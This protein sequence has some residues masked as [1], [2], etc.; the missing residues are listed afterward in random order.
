METDSSKNLI[1]ISILSTSSNAGKSMLIRLLHQTGFIESMKFF[2]TDECTLVNNKSVILRRISSKKDADAKEWIIKSD[3]VLLVVRESSTAND[4]TIASLRHAS[5]KK[6]LFIVRTHIDEIVN[7]TQRYSQSTSNEEQT[8]KNEQEFL[9][10]Q[11]KEFLTCENDIYLIG[12]H[13]NHK[14]KWDFERLKNDLMSKC[15]ITE[16]KQIDQPITEAGHAEVLHIGVLSANPILPVNLQSQDQMNEIYFDKEKKLFVEYFDKHGLDE[17]EQ[18]FISRLR[19]WELL[20]LHIAVTGNSGVGKSSFINAI[21]GVTPNSPDAAKTG[22]TECTREPQAFLHSIH[23]NLTFWDLPGCGTP[24][25]PREN[26]LKYINFEQFDVV[27][28]ICSG[29][30]TEDDGWLAEEMTQMNKPFFFLRSKIDQEITNAQ[31]DSPSPFDEHAVLTIIK[32]DCVQHLR[33]YSHHRKVYLVSGNQKYLHRWDMNDFMHD[34]CQACPQLKRESLVFSMNAH[35]RE[36]VRVKVEYLRKRQ[37]LICSAIAAAAILPVPGFSMSINL[38]ACLTEAKEYRQQL[39]L[40]NEAVERLAILRET[41]SE[42]IRRTINSVL[43]LLDDET[44]ETLFKTKLLTL[45]AAIG[46][47][48]PVVG[49]VLS[50]QAVIETLDYF[51]KMMEKVALTVTDIHFGDISS[52]PPVTTI[53]YSDPQIIS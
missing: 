4:R 2:S 27:I 47:C 10:S 19:E 48:I 7:V 14:D 43:P 39:G 41:S 50:V 46:H 32:N 52:L 6:T 34:L 29:R 37:W 49:C 31:R 35:C 45:N 15:Q 9:W 38:L 20:S 18:Y 16:Q 23:Q 40:H 53:E 30:F 33:Q 21:R 8:I 51:L 25:Y 28:I 1:N 42:Y 11:Y 22:V 44:F 12:S 24:N 36:A 5:E 13:L 26:Y 3:I 17:I